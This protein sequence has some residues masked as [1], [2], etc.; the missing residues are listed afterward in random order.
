VQLT[1]AGDSVVAG[2]AMPGSLPDLVSR[3]R[4]DLL[5]ELR[6]DSDRGAGSSVIDELAK[7]R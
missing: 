7:R 5:E 1:S 6:R 3:L 4:N 2:F